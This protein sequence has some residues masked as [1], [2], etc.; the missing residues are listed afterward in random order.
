[1]RDRLTTNI[2]SAAGQTIVQMVMFV[3]LYR[4]LINRIGVDQLG[5][6]S[7]VLAAVSAARVSELGF[8]GSIIKYVA[9]YRAQGDDQAASESLQ[10]AAISVGALLALMVALAYP[11]LSLALPHVLPAAGLDAGRTILPFALVSIWLTS[12]ADIWMNALDACLRSGLRAGIMIIGSLVFFLLALIGVEYYGL[13]GLAAAQVAQGVILLTVGWVAIRKVISQLPILPKQWKIVHFRKM[14][15]YGI[16]FQINSAV[17]LLFEPAA[18]I[19]IGRYGGLSAAGYFEMAQRMVIKVRALV[20]ESNRVIVPVYAGM[21]SF[22]FDAPELYARNMRNLLFIVIPVFAALMALTPAICEAW[23]GSFQPQFVIMGVG[24]TFAWFLN[25]V[26][27]PAY[28]AYLG[29]G[30]LRWITMA[31]VIMGT[32]NILA[33]LIF[34]HFFGW[35][36]VLA[37]FIGSLLLGSLLPI[38]AYH[39]EHRIKTARLMS[40]PDMI[41]AG[42]CFGAAVIVLAIYWRVLDAPL[43]GKWTRITIFTCLVAMVSVAAIWFHPLRRKIAAVTISRLMDFRTNI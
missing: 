9:A 28:F 32:T 2:F 10:T 8:G 4:Y 15:G 14:L 5:T 37:S 27:A 7:L 16:N 31:H 22:K 19:L 26:S 1:M 39:Y 33:G 29:Q 17:I 24:L 21:T 42:V 11:L 40:I 43:A 23:V 12:V 25:T 3:M 34:G 41:S 13:L 18:K 35:Q 36:G 6:W 20:V 38:C 30:K